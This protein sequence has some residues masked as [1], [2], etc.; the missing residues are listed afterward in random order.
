MIFS[1]LLSIKSLISLINSSLFFIT[2]VIIL[3]LKIPKEFIFWEIN[4]LV[5]IEITSLLGIWCFLFKGT[6]TSYKFTLSF[7]CLNIILEGIFFK[8]SSAPFIILEFTI[9]SYKSSKSSMAFFKSLFVKI[10]NESSSLFS[11]INKTGWFRI[12]KFKFF[13]EKQSFISSSNTIFQTLF[14]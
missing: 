13:L 10:D 6:K 4:S 2:T 8:I 11:T 3:S 1:V 7:F 5:S 14:R 12:L 9:N